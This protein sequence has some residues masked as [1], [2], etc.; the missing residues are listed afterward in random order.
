M[1]FVGYNSYQCPLYNILSEE[2]GFYLFISLPR[3]IMYIF[4][5]SANHPEVIHGYTRLLTF[6]NNNTT[7]NCPCFRAREVTSH[8]PNLVG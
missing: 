6:G 8:C 5:Q 1:R 4:V 7:L 2:G 3:K